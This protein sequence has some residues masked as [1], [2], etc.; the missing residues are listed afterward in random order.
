MD[1]NEKLAELGELTLKKVELE[2]KIEALL[3]ELINEKE[4]SRLAYIMICWT[5]AAMSL[6]DFLSRKRL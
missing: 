4:E 3:A 1:R 5:I 2:K 6:P